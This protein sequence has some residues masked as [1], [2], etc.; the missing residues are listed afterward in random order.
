M[1]RVAALFPEK[2]GAAEPI[3][4]RLHTR[5][6]SQ[7]RPRHLD[8]PCL[9]LLSPLDRAY[10]DP[11]LVLVPTSIATRLAPEP[12]S[13]AGRSP[14]PPPHP[15]LAPA[16]SACSRARVPPFSSLCPP[17]PRPTPPAPPVLLPLPNPPPPP[18]M[19]PASPPHPPPS[20]LSLPPPPPR[21]PPYPPPHSPPPPPTPSISS[22]APHHPPPPSPPPPPLA[23][24]AP[25]PS[26][27]QTPNPS[28]PGVDTSPHFSTP[29]RLLLGPPPKTP[30]PPRVPPP[31]RPLPPNAPLE[32]PL[33]HPSLPPPHA[34]PPPVSQRTSRPDG[35]RSSITCSP[36]RFDVPR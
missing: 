3:P 16:F 33:S 13:L 34:T 20:R 11:A 1:R 31:G 22:P 24:S 23:P 18:K 9:H 5:A 19:H 6:P 27:A 12:S 2:R 4:Q 35:C 7:T 25:P 14:F 21:L 36:P 26:P 15:Y 30:P 32:P 10:S 17:S 29:R 8:S 28:S